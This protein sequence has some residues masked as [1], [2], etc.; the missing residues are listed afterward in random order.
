MKIPYFGLLYLIHIYQIKYLFGLYN[1]YAS[2][3]N[4]AFVVKKTKQKYDDSY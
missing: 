3:S 2:S 4:N 1:E